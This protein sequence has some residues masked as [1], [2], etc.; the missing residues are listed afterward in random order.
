MCERYINWLPLAHPQLGTWPA[1]QACALTG[2]QTGASLVCRLALNPLSHTSQGTPQLFGF[3][4]HLVPFFLRFYLFLERGKGRERETS[5]FKRYINWLPLAHP[6]LRTCPA[7]QAC[8]LTG[9]RT[10]NPLVR[11]PAL[12]PLSHTSQGEKYRTIKVV[13]MI[14]CK[15]GNDYSII[16]VVI[17][18]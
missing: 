18:K 7:T 8:V 4:F 17:Y 12:N 13:Y 14:T 3:F 1:P 11:R 2:N 10:G 16:W 9:N 6:Q 5:V 15:N